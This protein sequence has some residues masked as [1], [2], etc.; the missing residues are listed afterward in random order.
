[1][2][3]WTAIRV[4]HGKDTCR[5]LDGL[6]SRFSAP[7][8]VD[9]ENDERRT[10]AGGE[11]RATRVH[12]PGLGLVLLIGL[13]QGPGLGLGL[14]V[15]AMPRGRAPASPSESYHHRPLYQ[16][17]ALRSRVRCVSV[18]SMYIS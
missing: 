18:Y 16:P 12:S 4:I 9:S 6:Q 8:I 5:E 3:S 7:C 2:F 15:L 17:E 11:L 13:G 1:M 10:E 14:G